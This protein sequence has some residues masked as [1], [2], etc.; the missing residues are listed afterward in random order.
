MF[1]FWMGILQN[2]IVLLIKSAVT[3]VTYLL[4][5]QNKVIV[6]FFGCIYQWLNRDTVLFKKI[7]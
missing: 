1:H 4:F 6:L 3:N 2:I 7:H 5:M